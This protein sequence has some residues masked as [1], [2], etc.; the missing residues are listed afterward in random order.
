LSGGCPSYDD[1]TTTTS[2][3]VGRLPVLLSSVATVGLCPQLRVVAIRCATARTSRRWIRRARGR[4]RRWRRRARRRH[5]AVTVLSTGDVVTFTA[6]GV[7]VEALRLDRQRLL[8]L[9]VIAGVGGGQIEALQHHREEERGLLQ[10]ETA[11]DAGALAVA[12]RLPGV[13]RE[14]LGAVEGEAVGV[15]SSASHPDRR[16]AVQRGVT[17]VTACPLRSGS[18]RHRGW[19]LPWPSARTPVPWATAAA[20]P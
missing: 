11:P 14:L 17:T 3:S 15:D 5:A 2:P 19:C 12:E 16:I 9:Q 7:D 20:T 1:V 10:R 8:D 6:P 4:A 18:G 13:G